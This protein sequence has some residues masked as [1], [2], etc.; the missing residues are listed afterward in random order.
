[1]TVTDVLNY[2][3]RH[4]NEENAQTPNWSDAELY[5]L[6]E[7]KCN[8]VISV[9]GLIEGKDTSTTTVNG[10]S[11]YAYPTNFVR[12]R[13]VW[14]DGLPLKYVGFRQYESRRPTGVATTGTPREFLLWNNTIS[15]IPT[16]SSAVTLTIF[17]EKKQSAITDATGTID[18]PALFH[19]AICDALISEM[20]M[21]DENSGAARFYQDKWLNV[22]IPAMKEYVK[23]R[24][25][26]GLPGTVIDTDSVQETEF[27]VI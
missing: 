4:H 17:G 22:H 6:I 19:H 3:R 13:R 1:M 27:G 26:R 24:R 11:D 25:R 20:Y 18:I 8:E 21:K 12:I 23:R 15:L 9:I 5:Q 2:V 14:F 7:A 10:T 16:P